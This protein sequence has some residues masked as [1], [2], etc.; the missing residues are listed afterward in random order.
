M[1]RKTGGINVGAFDIKGGNNKL[2]YRLHTP[3]FPLRSCVCVY[4]I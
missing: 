4:I 2:K 3:L 1:W